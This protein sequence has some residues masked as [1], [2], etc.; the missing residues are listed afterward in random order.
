MDI[1]KDD[2]EQMAREAKEKF[3][4]IWA[5]YQEVFKTDAGR[6]VL[7]DL[8][9]RHKFTKPTITYDR[10]G[11]LDA[12]A[13]LLAEGERMVILSILSIVNT[14]EEELV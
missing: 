10:K 1:N 12:S 11:R 14:K 4:Y 6:V 3:K 2:R 13:M 8:M 7:D 5:C 9:A